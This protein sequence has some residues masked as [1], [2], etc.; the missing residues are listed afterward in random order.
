MCEVIIEIFVKKTQKSKFALRKNVKNDL[1]LK[2]NFPQDNKDETKK[3]DKISFISNT[4]A[5]LKILNYVTENKTFKEYVK[6]LCEV[7]QTF[8]LLL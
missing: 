5:N 8:K 1:T 2:K 4:K 7:S 6:N 3:R